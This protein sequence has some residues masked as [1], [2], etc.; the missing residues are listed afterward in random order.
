[1]RRLRRHRKFTVK[2]GHSKCSQIEKETM[3]TPIA[4]LNDNSVPLSIF[5][6]AMDDDDSSLPSLI[7]RDMD[8]DSD[9]DDSVPS[10][11]NG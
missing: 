6:N 11:R 9:N 10:F 7:F 8:D 3:L 5:C 2:K 4:D 1:M